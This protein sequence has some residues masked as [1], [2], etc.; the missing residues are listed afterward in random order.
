M[1]DETLRAHGRATHALL[2]VIFLVG[3]GSFVAYLVLSTSSGDSAW[4]EVWYLLATTLVQGGLVALLIRRVTGA[5]EHLRLR[6]TVDQSIVEGLLPLRGVLTSEA[7]TDYE[8]RAVVAA[9][10]PGLELD[11]AVQLMIDI[12][13][14]VTS[15]PKDVRVAC[16]AHDDGERMM[17]EYANDSRYLLRWVLP[18]EFD[19]R[20]AEVFAVSSLTVDGVPVTLRLARGSTA[21]RAEWRGSVAEHGLGESRRLYLR[22]R[23]VQRIHG[24]GGAVSTQLFRTTAGARFTCTVDSAVGAA[25]LDVVHSEVTPLIGRAVALGTFSAA[26][27]GPLTCTVAWHEPLMAGSSVLFSF[28]LRPTAS[29]PHQ[30]PDHPTAPN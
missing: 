1:S 24:A 6:A 21:D 29:S 2:L 14:T 13:K 12:S 19:A 27:A 17:R 4:R 18:A 20:A 26:G 16:I 28:G 10:E 5:E 11:G 3:A 25:R 30:A 7:Q 8:W 15:L 22:Y 9:P 23:T